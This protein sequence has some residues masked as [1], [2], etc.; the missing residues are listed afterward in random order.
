MAGSQAT[1]AAGLTWARIQAAA[2][3]RVRAAA[4]TAAG[5]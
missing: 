5:A 3:S 1:I 4:V 2:L